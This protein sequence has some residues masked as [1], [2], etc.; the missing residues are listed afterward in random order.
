M[1][2]ELGYWRVLLRGGF[3]A[4]RVPWLVFFER[5]RSCG[6]FTTRFVRAANRASAEAQAIALVEA[7]LA[8]QRLEP[9]DDRPLRVSIEDVDELESF[10]DSSAPGGG[11]TF[12]FEAAS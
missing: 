3:V 10:G 6:F 9:F 1:T 8:A 2:P 5:R 12:Y 7:E 11:F 4:L